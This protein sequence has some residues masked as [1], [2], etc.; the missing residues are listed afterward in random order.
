MPDSSRSYWPPRQGAP[1]GSRN[2]TRAALGFGVAAVLGAYAAASF[3]VELTVQ[4]SRQGSGQLLADVNVCVGT[5]ADPDQ[6]GTART[7]R[8]GNARFA[9]LPRAPL[10]VVISKD[11]FRG[12]QLALGPLNT[13]RDVLVTLPRGGGG[14]QCAGPIAAVG[15]TAGVDLRLAEVVINEGASMTSN[16]TVELSVRMSDDP[17]HYRASERSDFEG[18]EWT[19]FEQPIRYRLSSGEG[20][21]T[22]YV[23]LRKYRSA[24]G[25]EIETLSNVASAG[26]ELTSR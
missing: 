2:H 21:K 12:R 24:V 26:I 17:T 16:R 4:I 19:P 11:G 14:P 13:D 8:G 20:E 1:P 5:P 9:E 23:Q 15:P 18:A 7:G 25:A 10:T 22:V 3:A 6:F